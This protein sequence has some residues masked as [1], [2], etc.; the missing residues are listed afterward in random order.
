M[1]KEFWDNQSKNQI[2]MVHDLTIEKKLGYLISYI[3][4]NADTIK[5]KD[6]AEHRDECADTIITLANQLEIKSFL[7]ILLTHV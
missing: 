7:Y 3:I 2:N 5:D 1:S 4:V 6:M